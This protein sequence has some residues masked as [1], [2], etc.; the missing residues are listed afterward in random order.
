MEL[1]LPEDVASVL[2]LTP[3]AAV[4]E[5][6]L[7]NGAPPPYSMLQLWARVDHA[8]AKDRVGRSYPTRKSYFKSTRLLPRT[9]YRQYQS[10]RDCQCLQETSPFTR[11]VH[12]TCVQL[13]PLSPSTDGEHSPSSGSPAVLRQHREIWF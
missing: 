12:H 10:Y 5:V 11:E 4:R 8:W 6:N 9:L 7:W 13:D 2:Y 1:P 3:L